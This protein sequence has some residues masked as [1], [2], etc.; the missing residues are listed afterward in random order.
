VACLAIDAAEPTSGGETIFRG[1][2][3][4]NNTGLAALLNRCLMH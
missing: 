4:L 2:L 1:D 3:K